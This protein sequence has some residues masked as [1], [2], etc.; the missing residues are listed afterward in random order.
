MRRLLMM[1][2]SVAVLALTASSAMAKGP[3]SM[4]ITGLES[5]AITVGGQEGA[6][7]PG[8]GGLL[9]GLAEAAGLWAN[10]F[11]RTAALGEERPTGDLG[12]RLRLSS[13]VPGPS[14]DDIVTQDVYPWAQGGAVTF[15]PSGQDYAGMTTRGGWF[16]GGAAL[17]DALTAAGV[18]ARPPTTATP[19][20]TAGLVTPVVLAVAAAFAL[21]TRRRRRGRRHVD[22]PATA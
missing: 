6:G 2:I 21:V 5:G 13:V 4:R 1:I 3:I 8:S 22:T 19:L 11:D 7:E 12:P 20:R 14:G 17:S 16:L 9:A 10:T 15:T 18:P